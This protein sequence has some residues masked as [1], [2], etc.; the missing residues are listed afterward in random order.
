MCIAAVWCDQ[1]AAVRGQ[2]TETAPLSLNVLWQFVEC[3][4]NFLLK[5]Q[6]A[7]TRLAFVV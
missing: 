7:R 5:E 2:G 6:S 1:Y 3:L 4:S